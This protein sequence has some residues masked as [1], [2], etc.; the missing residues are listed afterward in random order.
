MS[1]SPFELLRYCYWISSRGYHVAITWL[2]RG[3]H[4]RNY[5]T[6][7]LLGCAALRCAAL[8][9]VT[10]GSALRYIRLCA[11]LRYMR[12]CAALRPIESPGISTTRADRLYCALVSF[13]AVQPGGHRSLMCDLI[14]PARIC[15]QFLHTTQ[16]A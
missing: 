16:D 11:A 5:P 4:H 6:W 13:Y 7:L 14:L 9:C 10:C 2:S 12:L 8:R 15:T 3:Y 1:I